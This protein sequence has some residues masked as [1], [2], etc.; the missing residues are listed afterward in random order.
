MSNR[1]KAACVATLLLIAH[2]AAAETPTVDGSFG[3]SEWAGAARFELSG[4]GTLLMKQFGAVLHLGLE[5]ANGGIGSVLIERG[6]SVAVL[7]ASAA[8]GTAV[9]RR[10]DDAWQLTRRFE[11]CCR[12]DATG[13][14]AEQKAHR[15]KDG[16]IASNMQTGAKH[17]MEYAIDVPADGLRIA[18]TLL[19][20]ADMKKVS[21]WPPQPGESVLEPVML[22]GPLPESVSLNPGAWVEVR[23]RN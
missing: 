17:Q 6:D 21:W 11:W 13:T 12:G 15:D 10:Q 14:P 4:G 22:T 7:H 8:I 9:Y 16:W 2:P 3:E 5:S 19:D 20:R 18:V 1:M 23:P